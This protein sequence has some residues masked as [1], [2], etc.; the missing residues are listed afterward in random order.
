[1]EDKSWRANEHKRH[2]E[3]NNFKRL[4]KEFAH[5]PGDH[6]IIANL[7]DGMSDDDSHAAL[8]AYLEQELDTEVTLDMLAQ[9]LFERVADLEQC[10]VPPEVRTTEI[11][12]VPFGRD[13]AGTIS[14]TLEVHGNGFA[15][16]NIY[17]H[18]DQT[19]ASYRPISIVRNPETGHWSGYEILD[20][21]GNLKGLSDKGVLSLVSHYWP[22]DA[23]D[24]GVARIRA[25]EDEGTDEPLDEL[26]NLFRDELAVYGRQFSTSNE[27]SHYTFPDDGNDTTQRRPSGK[28]S[29]VV[30][31]T[32]YDVGESEFMIAMKQSIYRYTQEGTVITIDMIAVVNETGNIAFSCELHDSETNVRTTQSTIHDMPAVLLGMVSSLNTLV[33]T[34]VA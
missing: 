14:G 22:V 32:Q 1:M 11:V 30:H 28:I 31:R 25:I 9:L 13:K 2:M 34:R 23:Y 33:N 29:L 21:D 27:Y 15:K 16:G 20:D 10:T 5:V 8:F 12:D 24:M 18:P 3:E 7:E 6:Q 26:T 17:I 4:E 19:D